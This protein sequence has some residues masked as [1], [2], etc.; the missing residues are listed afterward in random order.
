V[1]DLDGLGLMMFV[2]FNGVDVV[3]EWV[4]RTRGTTEEGRRLLDL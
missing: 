4:E 1:R 3:E 2:A